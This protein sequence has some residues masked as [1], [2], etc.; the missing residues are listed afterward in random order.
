MYFD[1]INDHHHRTLPTH[2]LAVA[3]YAK[4][5]DPQFAELLY[6]GAINFLGWDNQSIPKTNEFMQDPRMIALG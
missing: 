6:R 5:Q 1:E 2:G 3:F 4:P